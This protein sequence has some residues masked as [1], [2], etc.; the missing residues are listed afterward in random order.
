M[1]CKDELTNVFRVVAVSLLD[2]VRDCA[3]L[4]VL[5]N[6]PD[7]VFEL[8]ALM[9]LHEMDVLAERHDE[10]CFV[11]SVSSVVLGGGRCDFDRQDFAVVS[12]LDL[13]DFRVAALS[14]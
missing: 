9:A 7:A 12:P 1:C 5:E 14:D 8:E 11:L 4:E 3:T 13:I 6:G 2:K 10:A